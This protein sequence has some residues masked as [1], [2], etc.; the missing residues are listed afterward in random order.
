MYLINLLIYAS[1]LAEQ[2]DYIPMQSTKYGF[3]Y[4]NAVRTSLQYFNETNSSYQERLFIT[5]NMDVQ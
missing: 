4:P 2:K 5:R 3:T 1:L